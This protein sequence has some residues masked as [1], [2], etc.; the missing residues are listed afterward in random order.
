MDI[1]NLETEKMLVNIH[2]MLRSNATVQNDKQFYRKKNRNIFLF[3]FDHHK[4]ETIS[5]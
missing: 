5:F 3:K 1:S 4:N 2:K